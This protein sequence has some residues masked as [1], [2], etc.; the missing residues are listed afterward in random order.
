VR[1]GDDFSAIRKPLRTEVGWGTAHR[2]AESG[3]RP[4]RHAGTIHCQAVPSRIPQGVSLCC[5][6]RGSLPVPVSNPPLNRQA[7]DFCH[8]GSQSVEQPMPQIPV[9]LAP[10]PQVFRHAA[11]GWPAHLSCALVC[12]RRYRGAQARTTASQ[13]ASK[14]RAMWYG[15]CFLLCIPGRSPLPCHARQP[16]THAGHGE[17]RSAASGWRER[18]P[19]KC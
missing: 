17:L 12:L 1:W 2:W 7:G 5:R 18:A 15:S 3:R 14:E 4:P 16:G 9:R 11:R 8:R 6:L 19:P 10:L 13:R